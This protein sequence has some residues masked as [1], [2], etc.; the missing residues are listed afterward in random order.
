[1]SFLRKVSIEATLL[2]NQ[3]E[4]VTYCLL[5]ICMKEAVKGKFTVKIV[6]PHEV[7]DEEKNMLK[8]NGVKATY[9]S[10]EPEKCTHNWGEECRIECKD[11]FVYLLSW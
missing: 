4:R 2:N 5:D 8:K 1:M 10:L 9:I 6:T 11:H 7:T 3:P